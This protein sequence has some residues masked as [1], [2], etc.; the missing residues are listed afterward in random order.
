MHTPGL[1]CNKPG[2]MVTLVEQLKSQVSR[3]QLIIFQ[4]KIMGDEKVMYL[5]WAP[6]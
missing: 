4:V 5:C 1:S 6:F 3:N 2:H